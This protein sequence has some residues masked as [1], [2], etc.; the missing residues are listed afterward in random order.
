M[1]SVK[2]LRV[3]GKKAAQRW[4]QYLAAF[5]VNIVSVS[6]GT[7]YG[8]LT[9]MLPLLQSDS[10]PLGIPPISDGEASWIASVA[11]LARLVSIP[12]YMYSHD[13][14]G[15][16]VT[17]YLTAAP[18]VA[19]WAMLLAARSAL[20]LLVA[21]LLFGVSSAG[22]CLLVP[23]YL[24]DI[25][26]D[27]VKGQLGV[28]YTLSIDV[29]L[30]MSYAMGH[31][32]SY[33]AYN[34]CCLIL[35]IVF[36]AAMF[37]LPESPIFLMTEGKTE[38]AKKALRWL[39]NGQDKE[40]EIDRLKA[41]AEDTLKKRQTKLSLSDITERS[42]MRGILINLSLTS[43]RYLCG[44]NAIMTYT[45]V[46]FQEAGSTIEPNLATILVGVLVII[47]SVFSSLVVERCGRRPLLIYTTVLLAVSLISLGAFCYLRSL[48]WDLDHLGW[49]P[50]ACMCLYNLV[51][52]VALSPLPSAIV[53]ETVTVHA[54]GAVQSL[55]NIVGAVFSFAV[56]MTYS[57][58][59][60]AVGQHGCFW[61]Y[62]SVCVAGTVTMYLTVPE[63]KNR[64][65][66]EVI[67][68][69]RSDHY[70][71][72]VLQ[73][74]PRPGDPAYCDDHSDVFSCDDHSDVFSC[75]GHT[76][77]FSC[78]G[79]TDVF[80]CD[81]HSDVFSCDD[82]SDVFSCGGHTD[83]FSC[84]GHTDVLSCGDQ[85]DVISCGCHSDVFSC[86]GHSDVFSCGGHCDVFSCGC[87]SDVF[88]CGD[89]CD[90]FSCGDHCGDHCD[91]FSCGDHCD[92][93]SCGDHCDVFSCGDHSDVFS[94]GD[95]SE[96]RTMNNETML[97]EL[98]DRRMLRGL[99]ICL[100][101]TLNQQLMGLASWP[102]GQLARWPDGQMARWPDDLTT[103]LLGA[104]VVVG[105]FFSSLAIGR[106]L[107]I[108]SDVVITL[109]ALC[110]HIL[111]SGL[112][113]LG[114]L[115]FTIATELVQP[116]PPRPRVQT[117]D[118]TMPLSVSTFGLTLGLASLSG[119]ELTS[120]GLSLVAMESARKQSI[121]PSEEAWKP[122]GQWR[123][124][125]V[126]AMVNSVTF[127]AGTTYGWPAPI[128]PV[129]QSADS[130]VGIPPIT[131][132][133]ASWLASVYCLSRIA[134]LPFF[135][136][137]I[138]R[139]GCKVTGYCVAAPF[140]VSYAML[141]F[142]NS[143]GMLFWARFITGIASA[144]TGIL[145]PSYTIDIAEDT[146]KGKLNVIYAQTMNVGI[147]LSYVMGYYTSYTVFHA[148][149]LAMSVVF[150]AG[151]LWLPESPLFLMTVGRTQEA[152]ET[153]MWLRND[154]ESE[155]ELERTKTRAQEV[156]AKRKEKVSFNKFADRT[157]LRGLFISLALTLNQQLSGI[158]PI[159]SFAVAIF[160]Q[161]GAAIP[162]NL[163]TILLGVVMIVGTH[164]SS[165][166]VEK[167]GRRFLLIGSDVVITVCLFAVGAY[168]YLQQLG[169]D[170]SGV[171]WLPVAALCAYILSTGVGLGTLPFTIATELVHPNSRGLVQTANTML[172]SVLAFA[173]TLGFAPLARAAGQHGCFW[174]FS[175]FCACGTVFAFLA[176]P[177]T[178][179]RSL[180]DVLEQMGSDGFI[181]SVVCYKTDTRA[182]RTREPYLTKESTK[183]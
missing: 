50:L 107:P 138:E 173:S 169:R 7:T 102:D 11:T 76:D 104:L 139:Y 38:E 58:L 81:D 68:Q 180:E 179:G 37:W 118:T 65:I 147:T 92:V 22:I 181:R 96:Q 182:D 2:S 111:S 94:C 21:R 150:T 122:H 163:T 168:F 160:Q 80:S 144:G 84:G 78:G 93:F 45:V 170:V 98:A 117:A 159:I 36:A 59:T 136:Y 120:Q 114:T 146:N 164:L 167:F 40:L 89:H 86:G 124:Y 54:R 42:T 161:A 154:Q 155:F 116:R 106:L 91:V 39:R 60:K 20:M 125:L 79:H 119:R 24:S 128:L 183:A 27:D 56:L 172:L 99:F 49:L 14:L 1:T 113:G 73:K 148:S 44:V 66:E 126:T 87:H 6:A 177:E 31:Y 110:V 55:C 175:A 5:L 115:P 133:E 165:M 43:V 16:R 46:I 75:G 48:G 17:A 137:I 162:P 149:C 72:S 34:T 108:A 74:R 88:S 90:V 166:A 62:A 158:G 100:G 83:V 64:S 123:Q 85:S 151:F 35:P 18:L 82:H 19:C 156:L 141:L 171:G 67:E 4:H 157:M 33:V 135:M 70:V 30:T 176:L 129:L 145:P 12:A 25:A 3:A 61:L 109:S 51:H 140:V 97:S 178:K 152:R 105:T 57:P 15:R 134:A 112:G 28:F 101:L 63:T 53:N 174:L 32:M 131:D 130:P 153:L 41:R 71:R 121:S 127:L 52:G 23:S 8:W 69:L 29:G 26:E 10:S 13:R 9:P 95:H 47:G 143:M 132:D 103:I 142:A 77:V